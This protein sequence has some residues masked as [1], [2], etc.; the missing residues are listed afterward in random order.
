MKKEK[1]VFL[2]I[3]CLLTLLIFLFCEWI[4]M[5]FWLYHSQ[6]R[7]LKPVDCDVMVLTHDE[8]E[9]LINPDVRQMHIGNGSQTFFK[10]NAPDWEAC[11]F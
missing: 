3:G 7:N 8:Y 11:C 10:A 5:R 9:Q 4:F 1:F 6:N 2:A